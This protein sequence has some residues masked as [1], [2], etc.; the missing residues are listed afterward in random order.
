MKHAIIFCI[1]A[2]LLAAPCVAQNVDRD[3]AMQQ[4]QHDRMQRDVAVQHEQADRLHDDT[5]MLQ[6]ERARCRME[7]GPARAA[8]MHRVQAEKDQKQRDTVAFRQAKA[9]HQADADTLQTMHRKT[10]ADKAALEH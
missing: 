5:A 8:C 10:L 3:M 9:I 4:A 2:L 6:D 7:R 1:P